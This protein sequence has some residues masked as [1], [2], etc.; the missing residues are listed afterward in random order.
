MNT[1]LWIAVI[2]AIICTASVVYIGAKRRKKDINKKEISKIKMLFKIFAVI[3]TTSLIFE[4]AGIYIT[5][6]R[7]KFYFNSTQEN[8][9]KMI[10]L[11]FDDGPGPYTDELID[12]LEKLNAKASFFLVGEK[13]KS[14][15]DTVAKIAEKGHLIGN[16]TYSHI[17]LTALSPDE[18][19]KEIDKTNEEIKAIT[20]EAPQFFRPPFGRY[21]SDTLNYVDMISVR[22]SKDTIDWK[23]EDEERLYRYLIKNAGDG[24]IFLM[25]DVE[26]TTVKGV[27]RAIETLQKQGYK[28][29]RADELLCRN[30]DGLLKG[31]GYR[32]CEKDKPPVHF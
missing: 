29:V 2:S 25:H 20:G 32:K 26:K 30:G 14:Y 24:E 1:N 23:Y 17:K 16:H 11:T 10:A 21:N 28:F 31:I 27:L 8:T 22:W 15:P 13:I 3:L 7:E 5:P 19:K 4:L 12:G 6:N 9:D 18:I